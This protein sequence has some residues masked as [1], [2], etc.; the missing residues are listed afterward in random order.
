MRHKSQAALRRIVPALAAL[1]LAAQLA[2]SAKAASVPHPA[3]K[4]AIAKAHAVHHAAPHH[5]ATVPMAKPEHKSETAH[6]APAHPPH[7]KQKL[8]S[9]THAEH[10]G[11]K[12][13]KAGRTV[14]EVLKR[15][16]INS[17]D[18]AL[19]SQAFAAANR[20]DWVRARA[21][22]SE[23]ADPVAR[24]IVDWRYFLDDGGATF[25]DIDAFL[26]NHSNWPRHDALIARAER[27]MP[28]T[29]DPGQVLAWYGTRNPITGDGMIRLGEALMAQGRRDDGAALIRKAWIQGQFSPF[30]ET[31]ILRAH[32]DL[33]GD[34]E[35]RARLDQF[36]ARDDVVGAK[37]QSARTDAAT[38]RLAQARLQLRANPSMVKTIMAGLP[39]SLRGNTE[40]LF[41]QARA[42]RLT[43][44]DE[45]A[46]AVMLKAPA[47]KAALVL[48]DHW[49]SERHIMTR[50]ALKAG[51]F[52]LAYDMASKS[53]A[54]SASGFADAAF[55]SGWI[56]LRFL[57]KP[58]VALPHFEALAKG[59]ALPISVARAYYWIG[60]TREALNQPN[61]AIAAYR[62][63]A[64]NAATF[65]GQLAL[66]RIDE[67]PSLHL[68]SAAA[69][70]T[71]S[72]TAT[73]DADER[74]Q[75]IR[76]LGN[77]GERDLMRLFAVR[78]ANDP[79]D[80]KHLQLLAALMLDEADPAMSVRVA[81]LA[82][83][84]DMLL[85]SYLAPVIALPSYP[86]DETGPEPALVLGLTRQ[87]S[88]FDSNAV[89][90]AG[91]RGLMQLMPASARIAAK[92]HGVNFRL[93]DL[94]AKPEYNMRLGMNALSDFLGQWSG[95]Y[96]LSIAA[97]NAGAGNVRNW[98][99][100]NGDPRDPDIDPI[101]WIERIPFGETR[102]YVQRV[103]E[104]IEIYR[105]RLGGGDQRLTILDDLY[106]PNRPNRVVVHEAPAPVAASAPDSANAALP[107]SAPRSADAGATE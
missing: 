5:A 17:T 73:F 77:L 22:A 7:P 104:N 90:G 102:N 87:E 83:Y 76:L 19:L 71:N 82:S 92:A 4:P 51:K 106:R 20:G 68:K 100:T 52:D 66:A 45:D 23:D 58:D 107:V 75:A 101:D 8:A 65:Y 93:Q 24:L 15:P 48:P 43:H 31:Q 94:T 35:Q 14:Q 34:A 2:P 62:K 30:E 38:Q 57:H 11:H 91:A 25:E 29:M 44:D 56:A 98:I 47:D 59:V 42:L 105:N 97:Y 88:E 55:L 60:R 9:N 80:S 12:G 89:S 96:V 28:A 70:A 64:H 78:V 36:F 32:G 103:L 95:S 18:H 49:W 54:D 40:L 10:A 79:P 67:A 41:D 21:L 81:K 50:D 16:I 85:L 72:E 46:W 39:E 63:A 1:V 33:I 84:N 13:K 69:E 27:S 53:V 37:R 6:T 3:A 86:G 74:V 99:E 26:R 61:E